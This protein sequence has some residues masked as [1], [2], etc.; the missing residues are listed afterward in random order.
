MDYKDYYTILGIKK[1]ATAGEIKKRFRTLAVK[2]HPDKNPGN[3]QAEEKFKEINEAYEVL[4][5]PDKRKKYDAI[6]SEWKQHA[7]PGN[8]EDFDWSRYTGGGRGAPHDSGSGFSDFFEQFFG[9]GFRDG[10]A[11]G[12]GLQQYRMD[13]DLT[14]EQAYQGTIRKFTV[15]GRQLQITLRPGSHDGQHLRIPG[16]G[17]GMGDVHVFLHVKK[18]AV[19]KRRGDDLY[20]RVPVNL[21]TAMMGGKAKVRTLKGDMS[22]SIAAGTDNGKALR[23]R[24]MGMPVYGK[25]GQF[26]DLYAEISVSIPKN[27]SSAEKELVKKL[28]ALRKE[29]DVRQ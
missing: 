15:E 11:R 26:G 24:G 13:V 27:L 3:K 1:S 14:L 6:G 22:V 2:Y 18:H 17:R 21:Y 20:C 12:R 19:Y 4:R 9:S 7:G 5:D 28:A 10:S 29:E 16:R 25:E 23:L 8:Q